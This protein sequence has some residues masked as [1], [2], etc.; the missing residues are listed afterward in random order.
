MNR[1]LGSDK[2]QKPDDDS[3]ARRLQGASNR[4]WRTV[5]TSN[6]GAS[7][8]WAK[9]AWVYNK[10]GMLVAPR[11]RDATSPVPLPMIR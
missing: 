4:W 2:G 5:I 11:V 8:L 1:Q 7:H 6:L 9:A 10:V 3:T